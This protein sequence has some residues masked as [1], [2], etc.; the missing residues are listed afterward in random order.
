MDNVLVRSGRYDGEIFNVGTDHPGGVAMIQSL[1]QPN[2]GVAEYSELCDYAEYLHLMI[3][4]SQGV[5]LAE[6][7]SKQRK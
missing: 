7:E 4:S 2:K 5:V 6:I 3:Q 1:S